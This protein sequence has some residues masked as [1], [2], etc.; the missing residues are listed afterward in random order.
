[1]PKCL[2][3]GGT[4]IRPVEDVTDYAVHKAI[5]TEVTV[6]TVAENKLLQEV[7]GIGAIL[8]Y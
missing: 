3:C 1:M 5:E 8:R 7:G 6:R 2:F 4:D